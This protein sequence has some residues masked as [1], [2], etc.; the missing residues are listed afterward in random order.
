M[1]NTAKRVY[2]GSKSTW[3]NQRT[4]CLLM[5]PEQS[6]MNPTIGQRDEVLDTNALLTFVPNKEVVHNDMGWQH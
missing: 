6:L 1:A 2:N 3:S 4:F 5:N